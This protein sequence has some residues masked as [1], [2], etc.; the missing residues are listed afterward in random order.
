VQHVVEIPFPA[1]PLGFFFLGNMVAVS[2]EHG[3]MFHKD[4]SRMEKK[5]TP[6][7]TAQM[8]WLIA[9]GSLYGRHQKKN[10]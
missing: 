9:V 2:D 5:D 7:N 10:A 3:E 1:I 6:A 8:C 4:I